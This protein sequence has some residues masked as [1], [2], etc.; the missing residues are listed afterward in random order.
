MHL[1]SLLKLAALFLT[2]AAGKSVLK[3]ETLEVALSG[4]SVIHK[5]ALGSFVQHIRDNTR[6]LRVSISSTGPCWISFFKCGQLIAATN[7]LNSPKTFILSSSVSMALRG[8]T[9]VICTESPESKDINVI[10]GSNETD[11]AIITFE[12][13]EEERE[14]QTPTVWNYDWNKDSSRYHPD[15][16]YHRHD[17]EITNTSVLNAAFDNFIGFNLSLTLNNTLNLTGNLDIVVG[18]YADSTILVA[19]A[20]VSKAQIMGITGRNEIK[21][22][23]TMLEMLSM[24]TSFYDHLLFRTLL[25]GVISTILIVIFLRVDCEVRISYNPNGWINEFIEEVK[26]CM[27][28]ERLR[29]EGLESVSDE[30][31][32]NIIN[33]ELV[34]ETEM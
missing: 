2:S 6:Q 26:A 33:S 14:D 20:I 31:I 21:Q 29:T 1:V 23:A 22:P 5:T 12:I 30:E 11:H 28:R 18:E 17:Y 24:V 10:V 25:W 7:S 34:H 13:I 16:T 3:S 4:H 9:D 19:T 15:T 8:M 27:Q 32:D